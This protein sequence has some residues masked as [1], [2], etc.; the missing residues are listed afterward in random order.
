MIGA[1]M[2]TSSLI[3]G[4]DGKQYE[5]GTPEYTKYLLGSKPG[6]AATMPTVAANI[7][8]NNAPMSVK[9]IER[10]ANLPEPTSFLHTQ[11]GPTFSDRV[12]AVAGLKLDSNNKAL[13]LLR[14]EQQ[15]Q[16][17]GNID[18][19][20]GA[21]ADFKNALIR[22]TNS[23]ELQDTLKTINKRLKVEEN[24]EMYGEI[25]QK[26]VDAQEALEMGLIYEKDRPARMSFVTGAQ[27]T[28]QK[29]GL[30]TIGALQGTAAVVKGNIELARAYAT[31]TLQAIS[32]DNDRSFTALTTL[33]NLAHS[34]LVDL[35]AD[36][37]E[38]INSRLGMIKEENDRVQKNKDDILDLM[39]KY[40][41]A[42]QKGGV[43]LLDSKEDAIRKMLPTMAADEQLLFNLEV[44]AKQKAIKGSA[45][46]AT[47]TAEKQSLVAYKANGMTY[48]DAITRF[49]PTVG[50][51]FINSIYGKGASND[52]TE[53]QLKNSSY[54]Q[55][56]GEDGK[57]K[58]G[59][60]IDI[61]PK[62]GRLVVS[63][64]PADGGGSKLKAAA[65]AT[66]NILKKVF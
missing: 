40:P 11:K 7:M 13:D 48:E 16:V 22:V 51:D 43:T 45:T 53:E 61:D 10:G 4:T 50:T 24:M 30:A 6:V 46:G 8:G 23:T 41:K 59:T 18:N 38:L 49:A 17:E 9:D 35:R 60:T 19:A 64:A 5:L 42:F 44:Q 1:S 12:T 32:D 28:L 29:Q 63:S 65:S 56:L 62:N 2:A 36:E 54:A 52:T 57:V 31:G 58:P 26:I 33:L 47:L 3:T 66:W 39:I 37:K 55:F 20:K 25:Q 34:D 14:A 15:K 21:E 27:S